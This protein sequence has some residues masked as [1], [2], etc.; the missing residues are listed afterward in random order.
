MPK[1]RPA[2]AVEFMASFPHC[3]GAID[4]HGEEGTRIKLDIPEQY[5]PQALE[6]AAYFLNKPLRVRVEIAEG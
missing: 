5:K 1:R 4:H 2:K 3:A 6:M